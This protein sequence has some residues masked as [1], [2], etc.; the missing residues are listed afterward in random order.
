MRAYMYPYIL[1]YQSPPPMVHLPSS[2]HSA[3]CQGSS[4]TY[5]GMQ[6]YIRTCIDQQA[7]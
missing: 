5:A 3:S 2:P 7:Y 6:A 1:T 4:N